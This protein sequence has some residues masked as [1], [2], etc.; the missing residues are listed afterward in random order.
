MSTATDTLADGLEVDEGGP[1]LRSWLSTLE[2]A[3]E[4]RHFTARVDWDQEIGA[5]PAALWGT[6]GSGWFYKHV[7][8]VEEDIDVRDPQ[9]LDWAMAYRVN[10]G[11][12]DITFYGPTLGSPLDPSTPPEK[13]NMAKYGSGEWTRVLIDATRSWEFEPRQEWGGR[14]YPAINTIDPQLESRV[15]ARWEEYGIGIGY[16]DDGQ[17]ESLTMALLRQRLSE[18]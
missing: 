9:A 14:H 17:R 1:D 3:N 8:V 7:M 13:A 6:S 12:G 4:L 2:A 5:I 10:A 18:V 11:L 16:L 15:A